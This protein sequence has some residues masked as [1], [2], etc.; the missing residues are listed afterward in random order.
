MTTRQP[1]LHGSNGAA[2]DIPILSSAVLYGAS[3]FDNCRA[4]KTEH[5]ALVYGLKQHVGRFRRSAELALLDLEIDDDELVRRLAD[6]LRDCAYGRFVR[7]RMLAYGVDPELCGRRASVALFSLPVEGYAP[8]RP[9]LTIA[10][11]ARRVA[12]DL[13]RSLK[14]PSAYLRVRREVAAARAS[15]FD[16]VLIV[17]EH[18]RLSEASRA[19]VVILRDRLLVTPP[20]SEG[21]LPGVTKKILRHIALSDGLRWETRPI[22][23]AELE[24]AESILLTSSSLGVVAA[25]TIGDR[26]LA[27][28]GLAAHLCHRYSALPLQHPDNEFL[29]RVP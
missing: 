16:D 20:T 21:A 9:Q 13:P 7:I 14:S 3:V 5:G 17:N 29:T 26:L 12:G 11:S 19:N 27:E 8:P 23:A 2:S 28:D 6:A 24:R 4:W 18:G 15:G 1:V 10:T 25:R 22:E